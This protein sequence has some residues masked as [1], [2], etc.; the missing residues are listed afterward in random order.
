MNNMN[1]VGI[2]INP[3]RKESLEPAFKMKEWLENRKIICTVFDEYEIYYRWHE[4]DDRF[5]NMDL[6]V[7]LGGDGTFLNVA[8]AL[9]L[10]NIPIM[11]VN[12]GHLG[13]L[14]ELDF[15]NIFERFEMLFNGDFIMQ[16]RYFLKVSI[17]DN[18]TRESFIAIN[19]AVIS[20]VSNVRMIKVDVSWGKKNINS[21]R[22][23]GVI[24]ST[25]TGSTGYSLSAGGPIV[26][27]ELRT[28]IVTP[29]AP[30]TLSSRSVILPRNVV[31]CAKVSEST[32]ETQLIIDG[33]LSK[34]LT[35]KSIIEILTPSIFVNV[36]TF[37]DVDFFSI[38]RQKL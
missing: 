38:L 34:P 24:F 7:I 1:R 16:K 37:E 25:A 21:Y 29:I 27:P 5:N 9:A 14:T 36:I 19:D 13:F 23:D 31:L 2:F 22:G 17:F 26:F 6:A 33:A 28:I 35:N 11:G 8:R 12:L 15:D 18:Q 30:H 4:N 20:G 32:G 3:I 10:S